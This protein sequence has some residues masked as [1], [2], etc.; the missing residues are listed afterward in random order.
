MALNTEFYL[1]SSIRRLMTLP[2]PF[3]NETL[4]RLDLDDVLIAL[5]EESG[6]ASAFRGCETTNQVLIC[7]LEKHYSAAYTRC[8][9]EVTFNHNFKS[10]PVEYQELKENYCYIQQVSN[11]HRATGAEND[12]LE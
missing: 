1:T 6:L 7:D 4:V 12:K 8:Y 3:N 11:S 9:Q 5:D 10:C 2:V